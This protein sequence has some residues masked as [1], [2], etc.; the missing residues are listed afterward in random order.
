LADYL[1]EVR[2]GTPLSQMLIPRRTDLDLGSVV[3]RKPCGC[4]FLPIS[5][6]I[7]GSNG[8]APISFVA[9]GHNSAKMFVGK[10]NR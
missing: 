8:I 1:D 9:A 4:P 7:E 2:A 6:A 10:K 5:R 3:E